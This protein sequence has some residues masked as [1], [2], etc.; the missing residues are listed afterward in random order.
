MKKPFW[1]YI[2]VG[3][4]FVL[5]G[6]CLLQVVFL[7]KA[8]VEAPH[9]GAIVNYS[10]RYNGSAAVHIS[11]SA[12]W[13]HSVVV[14]QVA[15]S[16]MEGPSAANS[17]PTAPMRIHT[18][19]SQRIV[20]VGG[21]GAGVSMQP[22]S[23]INNTSRGIVYS[24]LSIPTVQGL[25]TSASLV[26]GGI[27]GD[28]TYARMTRSAAPRLA[29]SLPPGVCDQCQWIWDGEKWVC[30]VCG[31]DALDGCIH[32]EEYG[33][34]WCPIGDGWPVYLFMAFLALGYAYSKK[35]SLG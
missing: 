15:M 25:L 12:R 7:Q 33:H 35:R 24:Q 16:Q 21:G 29:P 23:S 9:V 34:C 17:A 10:S 22:T 4:C 27:T 19:S 32:E 28:E 2:L 26:R 20:E 5:W 30:S 18:T 31:S 13:R 1:L 11:S 14:P 8:Y 6:I 3:V